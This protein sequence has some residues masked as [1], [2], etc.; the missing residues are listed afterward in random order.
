MC[1]R[2]RYLAALKLGLAGFLFHGQTQTVYIFTT[3]FG[4]MSATRKLAFSTIGPLARQIAAGAHRQLPPAPS[5]PLGPGGARAL[6]ALVGGGSAWATTAA[7][8]TSNYRWD[9]ASSSAFWEPPQNSYTPGCK[10]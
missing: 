8:H 10:P 5:S 9:A 4:A 2:Y 7:R 6:S 1:Y 3:C